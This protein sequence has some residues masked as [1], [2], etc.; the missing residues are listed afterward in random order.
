MS[1]RINV[2]LSATDT[3]TPQLKKFN[4]EM[5]KT[6]KTGKKVSKD[7]GFLGGIGKEVQGAIAGYGLMQVAGA[8]GDL[9][10]LGNEVQ[11]VTS[12]FQNMAG[13][14]KDADKLLNT[15]RATT[16]NVVSDFDLMAG[17]G[18]L[19]R[20]GLANSAEEVDQLID[21]A[22]KLKKPTESAG[23]AI[24]N[25]SLMLANQSVARLDSFGIASS[26]VRQ[27][28]EELLES[29]QALNRE[30][31]FKMAV[32][33][34]GAAAIERLGDAATVG[35]TAFAKVRT[36]VENATAELG[37]FV[38]KAVEAGAQLVILDTM[39]TQLALQ[40]LAAD[41]T[42]NIGARIAAGQDTMAERNL[43]GATGSGNFGASTGTFNFDLVATQNAIAERQLATF[44]RE[45]SQEAMRML[46]NQGNHFGTLMDFTTNNGG[47]LPGQGKFTQA[48]DIGALD[49]QIAL[50]EATF[51]EMKDLNEQGIINDDQLAKGELMLNK[52]KG[53]RDEASAIKVD[54]D[55][56]SL[57]QMQ[58]QTSGGRVGELGDQVLSNI[59][60]EDL[61][62]ATQREFDLAS[63][64]ETE[65]S[66][67]TSEQFA[68]A[69][70]SIAE[71]LG[72]EAAT[73]ALKGLE[74]TITSGVTS[75]QTDN[76]IIGTAGLDLLKTKYPSFESNIAGAGELAGNV[77]G[78][79][80]GGGEG[81][82]GDTGI[83][84]QAQSV[85]QT[86]GEIEGALVILDGQSKDISMAPLNESLVQ[87]ISYIEEVGGVLESIGGSEYTTKVTVEVD[88]KY[89]DPNGQKLIGE[90]MKTAV[91][92]NG[93]RIPE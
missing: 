24:E 13:G 83:E 57:A 55:S 8:I 65:L 39:M 84:S 82:E 59:E 81:E 20:M 42:T 93:G 49:K 90:Q 19:M 11:G 75:G 30:E 69:I 15:L 66:L 22:T 60:D 6:V 68:P 61:Q 21:M 25:F 7:G 38:A 29:G 58:G 47:V 51:A 80:F 18:Q 87:S 88:V 45:Q 27:R 76:Q 92:N 36:S 67:A 14:V 16:G 64:R 54:L 71:K 73:E 48:T 10:K 26:Q 44:T 74:K 2:I 35:E 46:M 72:V 78:N 70:A 91:N 17:A 85:I 1:N 50:M 86:I 4:A 31:A 40:N 32:M 53:M 3:A 43:A 56:I 23:E 5:D 33:E 37:M 63:G 28:I 9:N 77:F 89:N 79:L 41:P 62:K 52:F 34:Q 12:I